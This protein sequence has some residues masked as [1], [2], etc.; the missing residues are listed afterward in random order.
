MR[1]RSFYIQVASSAARMFDPGPVVV[2]SVMSTPSACSSEYEYLAL[3]TSGKS[4]IFGRTDRIQ[5]LTQT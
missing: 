1:E 4:L 3:R 2:D 5:T